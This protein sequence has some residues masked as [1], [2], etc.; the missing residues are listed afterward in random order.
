MSFP[1]SS[2]P[3]NAPLVSVLINNYNYG[4]FLS[5]AIDS[6]LAQTYPHVEII[7]VDDGS[8]DN[9]REVIERYGD[10]VTPVMKQ[11]GGQDSAFN[12]GFKQSRGEIVCFLDADDQFVPH[13]LARIAARFEA[14]PEAE[15]CFHSLLLKDLNTQANLWQTRAFPNTPEDSSTPCDFRQAMRWGRLPFYPAST[16]G[17]CFRRSLLNK[18]LPMPETFTATSADRY[19]RIAAM[20]IAPGYYL[21]EELTTQGIHGNNVGTL[22]D[23]NLFQL[24]SQI[25][26]G[27]LLRKQFPR[28]AQYTNRMFVRGLCAYNRTDPTKRETEYEDFIRKYRQL[29][30]PLDRALINLALL[31]HS[32]PWRK[33][34]SFREP[35]PRLLRRTNR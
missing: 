7:V 3:M 9:S 35:A 19:L 26:F 23:Q 31:Y 15:W 5:S 32:R 2:N 17:L 12:A 8:T 14:S 16:S 34:Y 30:S 22:N 4:R 21:A 27:Y 33:E 1:V 20:G 24:E 28:L 29:C 25:L 18:I 10:A 11:N 6:V 13:K